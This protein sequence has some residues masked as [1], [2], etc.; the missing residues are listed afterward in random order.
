MA[1]TDVPSDV[2]QALAA[3]PAAQQAF[4]RL[5]PSHRREYLEWVAAAKQ[6]ATRRR[7][8]DGMIE[9]LKGLKTQ[10]GNGEG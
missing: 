8:I 7:R 6:D 4:T 10:R 2:N 9:R 5:A 3:D 1:L